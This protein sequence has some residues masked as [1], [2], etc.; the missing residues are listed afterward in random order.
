MQVTD[1]FK[2][3][4]IDYKISGKEAVVGCLFKDC[5]N[6]DQKQMYI[7]VMTGAYYCHRCGK[8]GRNLKQL[9][10]ALGLISLKDPVKT[11]FITIPE[12]DII[13]YHKAALEN[14]M[15]LEYL[16][17][18][19]CLTEDTIKHFRLGYT[20]K[21]GAPIIII[22][23]FDK[24]NV[25]VGMKYDYFT[26]PPG[27]PKYTKE[28]GTKTQ[29]FNLQNID[30]TQP[31]V[32]TEGEYDAM[33]GYQYGYTNIGS[34]PNGSQGANGWGEEINR[35]KKF[36]LCF[37]NDSAGQG[38]AEL[39]AQNLGPS[40]CVRV[41]P[42]TKDLNDALQL[43]ISKEEIDSWFK[44]ETPFFNAP[45]T[46][47]QEYVGKAVCFL[48]D[49]TQSKGY[50]TGWDTFDYLLGGIRLKET[51]VIS[52]KTGNGKTTFGMALI[53][54]L[55]KVGIKCLI[56]S[57]EMREEKLLIELA[58]NFYRK[59]ASPEE[60]Q[61]FTKRYQN[62]VFLANVYGKWTE[63]RDESLMT[64]LFNLID[65]ASEQQGIKFVFI[66]HLRLFTSSSQEKE[67]ADIDEFMRKCVKSAVVN[68]LHIFIVVQPRKL[69]PGQRK[70][71]M[72][73]LKGSVNIE[74]DTSN[75]LLIHREEGSDVVE[76]NLEKNREFGTVGEFK[77]RFNKE[78]KANY[79]EIREGR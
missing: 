21:D 38:G 36:I 48:E 34:V 28:T 41:Y 61:K 69:P 62:D 2:E 16:T 7:N 78:S 74:Q 51:T 19:R 64:M 45:V 67:R 39:L 20:V 42:R 70:V 65:Y 32:I 68:D 66:D 43:G 3:Q 17:E 26:R 11:K 72:A 29:L 1:F 13:K 47:I 22:P 9:Q 53:G 71:T 60:I 77:L 56:V 35:A 50:S 40:K 52:G 15:A 76:F 54:N 4:R 46:S 30:L 23:Y 37:D 57:P 31:L 24:N 18:H 58:N 73:D 44:E 6:Y 63:N 49:T 79:E 8:K 27:L 55:L 10:Y 59:Q 14:P 75:V 12:S 5:P 25:C 33:S